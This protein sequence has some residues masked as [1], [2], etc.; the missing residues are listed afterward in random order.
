MLALRIRVRPL[1]LAVAVLAV[2]LGSALGGCGGV[3]GP[4]ADGPLSSGVDGRIPR[5]ENCVPGGHVQAFGDQQFTNHGHD[6]VV[7]VDRVV[8]LRPRNERLVGSYA[9]PGDWVIGVVFWPPEYARMPPTW[10]YRQPVRGF[11]LAP[12]KS[13]NLVLGVAAIAAGRATSQGMLVYYHDSSG[14]YVA[15]NYFAM[16]IAA[17]KSGC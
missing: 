15:R 8:L 2:A 17:T 14:S 12:G 6:A 9:V 10:K 13:F 16:T 1:P 4:A 3:G 5:G 7:V 11:R